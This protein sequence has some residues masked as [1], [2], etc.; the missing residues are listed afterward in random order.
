MKWLRLGAENSDRTLVF[1][2][3][4]GL[5]ASA[6]KPLLEALDFDG[7]ILAPSLRGHGGT[8]L[9][10][11]PRSIR[12][13]WTFAKDLLADFDTFGDLGTLTLAGHSAGSMT[14]LL[15]A[16]KRRPK[17]LILI[18]PIALPRIFSLAARTPLK[19]FTVDRAPIAV[20]AAKRRAHFSSRE[21]AHSNYLTKSFFKTWD[22]RALE[23]Y[24]DE[25]LTD[26]PAGGVRLSCE[27]AWE[28]AVFGAQAAGFWPHIHHLRRKG[29]PI[30]TAVASRNSTFP[31]FARPGF[32][33]TGAKLSE[34][35]GGHMW[36]VEQIS[37]AASWLS[38]RIGV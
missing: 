14:S 17:S 27:P 6:Y 19:R 35:E 36:P 1:T 34:I 22:E 2:H 24:L 5:N 33:A 3:A 31:S 38:A 9:P 4:T 16:R 26:D 7:R 30:H 11:D 28:S 8:D 10:A 29:L 37:Q 15:V 20:N 23:G 18:E 13:Y 21:E 32:M 12:S 25:G